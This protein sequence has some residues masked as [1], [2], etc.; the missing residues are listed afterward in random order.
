M[1]N[2]FVLFIVFIFVLT[3]TGLAF[4]Q[5]KAKE[6]K[7][8]E[9]AKPEA[10]KKEAPPPPMK[11][12]MGGIVTTIDP[13]AKKIT[14]H[15]NQVKRERTVTLILG[16]EALKKLDGVKVG[17]LVNAWVTGNTVTALDEVG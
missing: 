5:E 11:Y 2:V 10:E 14:L 3:S 16:K 4:A 17:D 15:Q 9:A 8:A 7:P 1:K 13:S 12:R 6:E